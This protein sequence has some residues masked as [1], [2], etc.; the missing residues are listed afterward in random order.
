MTVDADIGPRRQEITT[1]NPDPSVA[2]TTNLLREI[3]GSRELAQVL[4]KFTREIVEQQV[5]GIRDVLGTRIDHVENEL[6][7]SPT[8]IEKS[9]TYLA[10]NVD[11]KLK[12]FEREFSN[13]QIQ[14]QERDT[15]QETGRVDSNKAID[16]A[17]ASA[18]KAI[19]KTESGFKDQIT[20]QGRRIDTVSKSADEKTNALKELISDQKDRITALESR[21]Q[22]IAMQK[23]ETFG[24]VQ[25]NTSSATVITSIVFGSLG[26]M[27]GL[28]SFIFLLVSHSR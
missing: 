26:F 5:M 22:G 13:I 19:N 18:D 7:K 14:F 15:R 3:T 8:D 12:V 16:A 20:E 27:L 2:T 21:T 25:Q 24:Q 6:K 17:F 10:T 28:G 11:E 4:V 1:T 9:I 23:T